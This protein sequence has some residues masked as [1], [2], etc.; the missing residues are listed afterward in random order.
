MS[1]NSSKMYLN[2]YNTPKFAKKFQ[3]E[4]CFKIF[5]KIWHLKRHNAICYERNKYIFLGGFNKTKPTIF[6]KL[7]SVEI[8]I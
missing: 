4:K 8:N 2:V 6:D 7:E 1:Q 5:K 3:C